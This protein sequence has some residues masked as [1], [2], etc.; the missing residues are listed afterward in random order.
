MKG[1]VEESTC[2]CDLTFYNAKM[3]K[4]C[5][6]F[7]TLLS[8]ASTILKAVLVDYNHFFLHYI[9]L[10][11]QTLCLSQF[12]AWLIFFLFRAGHSILWMA[13]HTMVLSLASRD[14][15]SRKNE[16]FCSLSTL[17]TW[18]FCVSFEGYYINLWNCQM[19]FAIG[20]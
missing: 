11:E 4:L 1:L 10:P 2:G 8:S 14:K 12:W 13:L 7:C 15:W 5:H 16:S 19:L 17:L 9:V 20:K 18:G 6:Y 3:W